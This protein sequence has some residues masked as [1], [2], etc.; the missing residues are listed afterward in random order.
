ML[1]V[2]ELTRY[3]YMNLSMYVYF[4]VYKVLYSLKKALKKLTWGNHK[5]L[6]ENIYLSEK[7]Q[8]IYQYIFQEIKLFHLFLLVMM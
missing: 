4:C 3:V 7:N 5:Y 8:N 6:S 1:L 2:I